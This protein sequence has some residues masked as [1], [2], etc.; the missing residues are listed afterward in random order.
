MCRTLP[1]PNN[2]P[3]FGVRRV[4]ERQ[5][6]CPRPRGDE[7]SQNATVLEIN[8]MHTVGVVLYFCGLAFSEALRLPHRFAHRQVP[9][10]WR[11]E[12]SVSYV[13]ELII[14]LSIVSGLWMLPGIYA[15]TR[16]LEPFDYAVPR[17]A[18]WMG[19]ILFLVG[20]VIRWLAH[21]ALSV[22]WSGTL[23]LR[24]GHKLVTQGIYARLR[25]PIYTS[26]IL[27]SVS[28]PLLLTN[29][30]AG[31]SGL[32]A[33]ALLWGIRVPKEEAMMRAEFGKEY[34]QY[35]FQTGRILPRIREGTK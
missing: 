20:L 3:A 16:M 5:A 24:E 35:C 26:L 23:E 8:R 21:K 30:V 13:S 32:I 17:Y 10:Q 31:W 34:E 1:G 15:F 25:H 6:P 33:V 11:T 27:W 22:Q 29:A 2:R 19:I 28:Q 7:L 14:L 12:K 18:T 9:G 4:L